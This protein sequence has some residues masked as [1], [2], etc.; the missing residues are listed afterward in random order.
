MKL[1]VGKNRIINVR[2]K[3]QHGMKEISTHTR[4][5]AEAHSFCK[6]AQIKKMEVAAKIGLLTQNAVSMFF[7]GSN[8]ITLGTLREQWVLWMANSSN[9]SKATAR[10]YNSYV[11]AWLN[12][13]GLIADAPTS[14]NFHEESV[15]SFVNRPDGGKASTRGIALSAITSFIHWLTVKGFRAGNP[16]ALI[17]VDLSQLSHDQ[18]E[19]KVREPFTDEEIERVLAKANQ[20]WRLIILLAR[21]TGLRLS[22]TVQLEW[23]SIQADRSVVWTMKGDKRVSVPMNDVLLAEFLRLD[24]EDESYVFPRER[25]QYQDASG[26]AALS[27]YFKRLCVKAGVLDKSFHHLRHSRGT[28]IFN[29]GGIDAV[30][31]QLGH[32]SA[33]TSKG[34]VH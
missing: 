13:S 11:N 31:E 8:K 29:D 25:A 17:E 14:V 10:N 2:F 9:F 27:I 33:K 23:A 1:I 16:A 26:R 7:W 32:S 15:K 3:T 30:K 6:E 19:S 4:N 21:H 18:K 24:R 12:F 22:D 5:M 34:Y 20:T 28:E